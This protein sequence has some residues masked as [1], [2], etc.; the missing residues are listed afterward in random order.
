MNFPEPKA[1]DV[2]KVLNY[3]GFE[4]THQVGSHAKYKKA[5]HPHHVELSYHGSDRIPKGTF[6]SILRQAGITKIEFYDILGKGPIQKK[7][8]VENTSQVGI[9]SFSEFSNKKIEG[10]K[11]KKPPPG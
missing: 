3:L 4:K 5:G 9:I 10:S 2:E 11:Q 6:S 7:E 8:P 1:R